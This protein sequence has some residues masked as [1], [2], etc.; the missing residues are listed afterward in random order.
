MDTNTTST[1]ALNSGKVMAKRGVRRQRASTRRLLY[2]MAASA[3]DATIMAKF[4]SS[5]MVHEQAAATSLLANTHPRAGFGGRGGSGQTCL[6]SNQIH[7]SVAPQLYRTA[8]LTATTSTAAIALAVSSHR[9]R[10]RQQRPFFSSSG[11]V[12]CSLDRSKQIRP[13]RSGD[14]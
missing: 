7:T 8:L 14:A 3:S 2:T 5:F 1:T 13:R 10:R 9:R 4:P 12:V 6:G 11:S